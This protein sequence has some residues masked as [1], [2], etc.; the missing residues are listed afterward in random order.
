MG[1]GI[2]I[3]NSPTPWEAPAILYKNF[4]ADL[5]YFKFRGECSCLWKCEMYFNEWM[6]KKMHVL[7]T[8]PYYKKIMQNLKLFFSRDSFFKFMS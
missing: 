4:T 3:C 2:K 8:F 6:V 5:L 1:W 7:F